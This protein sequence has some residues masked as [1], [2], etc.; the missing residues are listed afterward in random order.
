[1]IQR[2]I[3]GNIRE[4]LDNGKVVVIMGARQVGKSTLAESVMPSDD[5]TLR[6]SG[7]DGDTRRMFVDIDE[8]RLGLLI[9]KAEYVLVDEAQKIDNV[10]NMLKILADKYKNVRVIATVSSSFELSKTINESLTGRKREYCLYPL[11]FAEMVADTNA[12][13][14]CRMVEHRMVYGYYPEVV[15]RPNDEKKTL[16]E[17]VNSYL[18]KDIL[19]LGAVSKPD[20]LE[21]LVQAL[22]FQIGSV[23]SSSELSRL[24]GLDVKTVDKYLDILEKCYIIFR[25]PSYATNQRNELKFGRKIY[26]WDMGIRNAVIGNTAPLEKRSPEEVGHLWENFA[27]AERIK[28]NDYMGR[29]FVKHYFWRTQQKKE[30]DLIEVEDG[31]VSGFEFKK[32]KGKSVA[33]PAQ[34]AQLYPGASFSCITPEDM[35]DF[36]M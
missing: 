26:F 31:N 29:D 18:Y 24:V 5:R 21:T 28:R 11:S 8:T 15:S 7:D 19:S 14:E 10:G 34:F 13:E 35:L 2:K 23:I 3:D 33:M 22:A 36:F 1:M 16:K 30:I 27:V 20:R 9:G 17:L 32:S 4:A 6:L 25:L 12:Q